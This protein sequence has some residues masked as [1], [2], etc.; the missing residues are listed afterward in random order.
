M[1]ILITGGAGFIG[2]HLAD[3]F[4]KKQYNVHIFDN[5]LTG[6]EKNI[7]QLPNCFLHKVDIN[8]YSEIKEI[9]FKEKFDII[10][11][12]SAVV[13]VKRTLQSPDLVLNDL[14]GLRNIFDLS[15]LTKI[16][17]IFYSS[18]S[19]VYGEPVQLPQHEDTTPLNSK[20]PYAVIKNAGECFCKTYY[21]KYKLNFNIFR[22]FNTYGERQSDDFVISK[23]LY[24][25]QKNQDIE[26]YGDG[27]QA[28]TFC[29]ISDN[30]E[31]TTS[32]KLSDTYNNKILNIGNDK[33]YTIQDVAK[34]IIN[35]TDSKSQIV[36]IDPLKEGDMKRRQPDISNMKKILEKDLITLEKGL[37]KI[38]RNN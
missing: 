7:P 8:N 24:L 3:Y 18:S 36:Y 16:K 37:G 23:F 14:K 17:K 28:R 9:M 22:F 38:I 6:S 25:A 31:A 2:S 35:L 13:G 12:Y 10:Y 34:L 33:V 29:Y 30:I 21:Q 11:H 19:E 1:K 20:L 4:V 27:S 15:I 32:E 5:L 26:I